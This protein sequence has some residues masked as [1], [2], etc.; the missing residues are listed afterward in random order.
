MK[1]LLIVSAVAFALALGAFVPSAKAL[2]AAELQAQIQILM[3]QLAAMSPAPAMSAHVFNTDLTLG[4]TGS[5]VVALQDWLIAKGYLTMPAGVAKGYFGQLTRAAVAAFQ[6]HEGIT[7]AAGYFGPTTRAHVNAAAAVVVVPPPA[8]GT[9]V[10]PPPAD[11][12]LS[13]SEGRFKNIDVLGEVSNE[14]IDEGEN[15]GKVLGVELEAQDSD[16]SIERVDV[17]FEHTSGTASDK[18]YK[19]VE[20]VSIW[21]GSK[22]LKT[23]DVDAAS[24]DSDVYSFRFTGLKGVIREGDTGKLYV[25]VN[26][27]NNV[28]SS[29]TDAVWTVEIPVDG[30]RAVDGAG[31]SDTYVDSADDVTET[32]QVGSS[33]SGELDITEAT[34]NPTAGI[35]TISE[36]TDTSDVKLLVVDYEAK[37]SG[38]TIN[39]LPVGLV[40]SGANVSDI[41]K[42]V[43]LMKG[44]TLLKSKSIPS[45]AGTSYQVVFDDLNLKID[46]DD[47]ETL[48]VLADVNDLEGSF[49]EGDSVY[50]TTTGSNSAYDVED[51]QGD[52]VSTTD[53]VTGDAQTFYVD[54]VVVTLASNAL[55]TARLIAGNAQASEDDK[56]EYVITFDVKANGSDMYIDKG[57]TATVTPTTGNIANL[58]GIG[59]ATTSDST[60]STTT[61]ALFNS[62]T[63]PTQDTTAV[64]Y[65]GKGT[66]RRFS[67][68]VT[69][70]A[71]LSGYAAIKMTGFKWASTLALTSPQLYNFNLDSFKTPSVYLTNR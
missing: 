49:G 36:T 21:L 44:N 35:V 70:T 66:S 31:V 16:M 32:F 7:P 67:L 29:D 13:G 64:F 20:S 47:T 19:Y 33:G 53:S 68:N 69:A 56:A 39:D 26:A 3:A 11:T 18:L 62:D 63:T 48:T 8:G 22:K 40:A 46:E 65:I 27:V 71:G 54:N 37:S 58:D 51:A 10:V 4:A 38:I 17:D 41:V 57:T 50:A 43:K 34:S 28:D 42:N 55:P 52:S 6:V 25:S 30:I 23:L 15:D 2:T 24:E 45:S 1:K 9:V 5:E 60:T 59:Y 61:V 14:D 12:S